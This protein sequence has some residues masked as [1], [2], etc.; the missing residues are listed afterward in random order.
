MSTPKKI[1][2]PVRL[3]LLGIDTSFL[4]EKSLRELIIQTSINYAKSVCLFGFLF[5]LWLEMQHKV[6]PSKIPT[7]SKL[8]AHAWFTTVD[9]GCTFWCVVR[10]HVAADEILSS[11][12]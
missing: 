6:D 8:K 10:F 9:T 1:T 12:I 7:V 2:V 5:V 4:L 3:E 11:G